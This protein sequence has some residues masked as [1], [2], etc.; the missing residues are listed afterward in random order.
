[1][2]KPGAWRGGQRWSREDE[3]LLRRTYPKYGAHYAARVLGRSLDAVRAH[4]SERGLTQRSSIAGVPR[5][6]A[7]RGYVPPPWTDA[8]DT[9][10]RAL[11][12]EGRSSREIAAALNRRKSDIV[13]RARSTGVYREMRGWTAEEDRLVRSLYRS[14]IP[15]REI[16]RRLDRS[17][18]AIAAH[19]AFLGIAR[20]RTWIPWSRKQ[21]EHLRAAY[22]TMPVASIARRMKRSADAVITRA[23]KLG[24]TKGPA[25]PWSVKDDA[26]LV[27]LHRNRTGYREIGERLG[28]GPMAVSARVAKLGLAASQPI[29]VRWT[30]KDDQTLRKLAPGH[31]YRTIAVRLGRSADAVAQRARLLGLAGTP[32]RAWTAREDAYIR[33]HYRRKTREE[34]AR[35]LGRT[36]PAVASRAG[37]LGVS[38]QREK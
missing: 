12:A 2:P 23:M 16:A 4:A 14:G 27:R 19:V 1:M 29:R 18:T 11:H 7:R 5:P 30:K 38:R 25:R 36:I 26:L 8:D 32:S 3:D 9:R 24:L 31:P 13:R 21:D 6:L 37:W 17:I 20:P 33:R 10:L 15:Y 34:I 22:G 28:R 35:A